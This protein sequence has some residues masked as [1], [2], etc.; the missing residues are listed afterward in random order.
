MHDPHGLVVVGPEVA[1]LAIGQTLQQQDR[2]G[3]RG[4]VAI[5]RGIMQRRHQIARQ[6][7]VV[8]QLRAPI[9]DQA[10][11]GA[12]LLVGGQALQLLQAEQAD[13]QGQQ[14]QR[15]QCQQEKFPAQ[16]QV[17]EHGGHPGQR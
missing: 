16:L 7:D 10:L 4:Q 3:A 15:Q 17:G 11:A 14:Q 6:A 1:I 9:T 5:G 2:L 13:Q 12:G 8:F